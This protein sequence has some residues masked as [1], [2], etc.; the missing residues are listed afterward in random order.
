MILRN[1][2][3]DKIL[4][5][6]EENSTAYG[7]FWG[8]LQERAPSYERFVTLGLNILQADTRIR[9]HWDRLGVMREKVPIR[10]VAAYS[11]YCSE[12]LQDSKRIESILELNDHPEL[13]AQDNAILEHVGPGNCVVGVSADSRN[14]G[15]IK[16][17]NAAFCELT[18]YAREQLR[19]MR[20]TSLIPRI[21]QAAHDRAFLERCCFMEGVET[22]RYPEFDAYLVHRS[23]YIVP[24]RM[25]LV[26]MPD[27]TNSYCVLA[28]IKLNKTKNGFQTV[29]ML[30]DPKDVVCA[31][32]SSI[33]CV[34]VL[35]VL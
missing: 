4:K 16:H 13:L 21:M 29:H 32:S 19:D 28:K 12:I 20:L 18:G 14:V 22:F 6:I 7:Q 1:K 15:L 5:L 31:V 24:V 10:M 8:T 26:A 23:G 27:Y 30:T 9:Q 3:V 11:H 17:F 25:Q 2:N 35:S 33:I 34:A